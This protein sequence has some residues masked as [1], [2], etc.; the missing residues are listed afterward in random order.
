MQEDR[1]KDKTRIELIDWI[2]YICATIFLLLGLITLDAITKL[3]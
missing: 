3:G 2:S 1:M